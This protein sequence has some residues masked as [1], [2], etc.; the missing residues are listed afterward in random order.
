MLPNSE[1]PERSDVSRL[2][3]AGPLPICD[4]WSV[5]L[6]VVVGGGAGMGASVDLGVAAVERTDEARFV[7]N[8]AQGPTEARGGSR[9]QGEPTRGRLE[10][11]RGGKERDGRSVGLVEVTAEDDAGRERGESEPLPR[12][13]CRR[14]RREGGERSPKQRAGYRGVKTREHGVRSESEG[15]LPGNSDEGQEGDDGRSDEARAE[16]SKRWRSA[17]TRRRD[18]TAGRRTPVI[19]C[20]GR[21]ADGR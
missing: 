18:G 16:L 6:A 12:A 3:T 4:T 2:S 5:S 14:R 9:P 21:S 19:S 8:E 17:G 11:Q 13:S 15:G 10:H 7:S 20:I 1:P